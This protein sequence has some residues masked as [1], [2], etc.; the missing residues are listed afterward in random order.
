MADTPGDLSTLL[1]RMRA[2]DADAG[3]RVMETLY[4]ELHRMAASRMRREAR[5]HTLQPTA[6]IGEA[7]LR[8]LDGP[9]VV[10]DRQHF[11]A[12]AAQAMRRV[13]VD[14]AR[15]KHASKRG[16]RLERV[17]LEGLPGEGPLDVD[18]LALD[19]A[20]GELARLD[21]RASRVVELRFF[22]GYTDKEVCDILDE[23]LPR[24]RRDWVFARS[25]LRTR[26]EATVR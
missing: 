16:G 17:T 14:H 5:Q 2:G 10:H 9:D 8:L 7:Y 13:L 21:P 1:A 24:V 26:F 12:L 19:E 3:N 18:V 22:G 11:L 4:S 20:L 15:Q 25:W 6:L 23:N